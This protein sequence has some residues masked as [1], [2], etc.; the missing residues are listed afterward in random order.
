MNIKLIAASIAALVFASCAVF[1]FMEWQNEKDQRIAL[2]QEVKASEVKIEALNS[3]HEDKLNKAGIEFITNL[4]TYGP[5]QV[6]NASADA[7]KQTIGTARDKLQGKD[8]EGQQETFEEFEYDVS[9]EVK[10]QG[11]Q[12]NKI[13]DDQAQ[14]TIQFE[15]LTEVDG[16]KA[17]AVN[18]V[19]LNMRYVKG[20]WKVSDFDIIQLL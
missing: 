17:A 10:I 11:S 5:N 4:L 1:F 9:S 16:M 12:Y 19:V 18:E 15:Q 20:E 7:L 2:E 3:N 13:A 6:H 14:V 8:A